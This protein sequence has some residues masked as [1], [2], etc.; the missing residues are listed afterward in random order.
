MRILRENYVTVMQVF[1]LILA[2][3]NIE[4]KAIDSLY[5]RLMITLPDESA[6]K[7]Y[8]EKCKRATGKK[9]KSLEKYYA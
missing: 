8:M 9:L 3:W 4:E 6:R 5:D 2:D 1:R 7:M